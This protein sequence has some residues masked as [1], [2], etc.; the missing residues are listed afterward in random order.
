MGHLQLYLLAA[1]AGFTIYL[2]LPVALI[3]RMNVRA[4]V[5]LNAL[6]IGVLV[7]LLVEITGKAI[8]T[9][10]GG[11]IDSNIGRIPWTTGLGY[12]ALL[13][14]GFSFGLLGLVGFE[15]FYVR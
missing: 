8:Q 1:V 6:S 4:N 2:G 10:A 9:V 15:R 5:F 13:I 7:F 12:L 11:L 3:P 14:G